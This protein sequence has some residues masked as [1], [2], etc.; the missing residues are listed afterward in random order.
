[1]FCKYMAFRFLIYMLILFLQTNILTIIP[2][3]LNSSFSVL[4][5]DEQPEVLQYLLP[6]A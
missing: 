4:T 6:W 2:T 1:M 5:D 3:I